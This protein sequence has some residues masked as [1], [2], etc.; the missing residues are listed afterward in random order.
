MEE[1]VSI[2]NSE[3]KVMGKIWEGKEMV[4]VKDMV[5]ILNEEGE[6]WAY[7]TVATF[8]KRLETKGFL[9]STKKGKKLYY[10]PLISREQYE[11]KEAKGF[12]NSKFG[13]SL[14]NFLVAFSDSDTIDD[15]EIKDLKAWLDEFDN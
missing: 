2:S 11:K 4:T 15:K 3:M 8:L 14:K 12:I 7:Q 10:F 13:G 1:N 5:G 6:E 9:S